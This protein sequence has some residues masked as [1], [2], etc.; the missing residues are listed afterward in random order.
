MRQNTRTEQ[1]SLGLTPSDTTLF[2]R[3][4]GK[5]K[6]MC[7]ELLHCRK[8]KKGL[9]QT[10]NELKEKILGLIPGVFNKHNEHLPH[11]IQVSPEKNIRLQY[12]E[13]E[14]VDTD[15]LKTKYPLVYRDVLKDTSWLDIREV[16]R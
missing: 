13:Q 9:M 3:H 16:K 7:L 12:K 5:L 14:R 2:Q 4:Q 11:D 6:R 8:T 1:K 10:E 15:K